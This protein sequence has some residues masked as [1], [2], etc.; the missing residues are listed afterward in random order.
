MPILVRN[1]GERDAIGIQ[2]NGDRTPKS[3]LNSPV[4]RPAARTAA[5]QI[6]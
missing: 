1:R 2:R 4:R 3:C 6:F 5:R